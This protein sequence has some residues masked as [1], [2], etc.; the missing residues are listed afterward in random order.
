MVMLDLKKK[1]GVF[2]AFPVLFLVGN[3]ILVLSA[4]P[5]KGLRYPKCHEVVGLP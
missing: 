4:G 1:V 3:N 2:K 5:F